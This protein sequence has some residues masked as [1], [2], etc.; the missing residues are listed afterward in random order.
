MTDLTND[1]ETP[2]L[3]GSRLNDGL[4]GIKFCGFTKTK[5]Q[6]KCCKCNNEVRQIVGIGSCSYCKQEV[7]CERCCQAGL[8]EKDTKMMAE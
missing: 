3:G 7:C 1:T 4:G 2:S 6:I 5:Y 8:N